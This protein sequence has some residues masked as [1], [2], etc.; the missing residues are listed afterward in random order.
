MR[1]IWVTSDT[2]FFHSNIL[3]F[4]NNK[5]GLRIRPEFDDVDQMNE[6]MAENWNARIKPGDIVYHLG[7]VTMHYGERFD[8]LWSG[9]NGS[10]R[11][12]VGNHDDVK[13]LAAGGYF[14]KIGM[15]RQFKEFGIV[16]THVPIHD[17]SL[18]DFKSDSHLLNVHG[19]IHAHTV[20]V[21]DS[22][23]SNHRNVCVEKTEYSPV[24]IEEL[25]V[26]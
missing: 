16:L 9:L 24:H 4:V 10:K 23:S 17:F 14:K 5:T 25:R 15:W 2:H 11:L 12:I 18:Y 1:D 21:G 6:V 19:H 20:M 8:R 26:K 7:D 13:R 22:A 3:T